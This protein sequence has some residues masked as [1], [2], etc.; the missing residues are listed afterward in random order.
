MNLHN[1]E[2]LNQKQQNQYSNNNNNDN[3]NNN[4]CYPSSTAIKSKNNNDIENNIKVFVRCRSRNQREIDEQ[5]NVVISTF[6]SSPGPSIGNNTINTNST[7]STELVLQQSRNLQKKFHFDKVFGAESDQ[8]KVY[9]DI[10]QS[11]IDEMLQGYNCTVFAYG[12][13]GTGKTYTMTGDITNYYLNSTTDEIVLSEHSGIIPR[14]LVDLF[15]NLNKKCDINNNNKEYSVKISFL[16]LYNEKLKDLLADEYSED[17]EVKIYDNIKSSNG[18]TT[19][20]STSNTQNTGSM[21]ARRS[22]SFYRNSNNYLSKRSFSS[23]NQGFTKN[24]DNNIACNNNFR[25]LSASSSSSSLS[26]SSENTLKTNNSNNNSNGNANNGNGNEKRESNRILSDRISH[27]FMRGTQSQPLYEVDTNV[28]NRKKT[29][30]NST[31]T[32]YQKGLVSST[33]SGSSIINP[34]NSRNSIL[35]KGVQEFFITS[36]LDGLKYLEEGSLKRQ[37]AATK[38]NDLSSRSHTI[39]TITTHVTTTDPLSGDEYVNVGKLN[40]VDLAGS[41]NINRSGAENKRAQEAGVINKSLLTLGRVINALVDHSAHIPYRES[42]L[43]RLLQDSLGGKTKTCIIATVS[44]AKVSMDETISTLEYATRAK[45]IKN[46][47]QINQSMVKQSCINEYVKII[48]NLRSELRAARKKEGVYIPTDTWEQ[49][50]N[51]QESNTTLI[52]EQKIKIDLLENQ[53]KRLKKN[54]LE[55]CNFVKDKENK[56]TEIT[57]IYQQTHFEKVRME[58]ELVEINENLQIFLD[59]SSIINEENLRKFKQLF[60]KYQSLINI[61]ESNQKVTTQT[62]EQILYSVEDLQ[63]VISHL[64]NYNTR[65]KRVLKSVSNELAL[66]YKS[67]IE[68]SGKGVMLNSINAFKGKFEEIYNGSFHK[69]TREFDAIIQAFQNE[70]MD[71]ISTTFQKWWDSD[72]AQL[73]KNRL[74]SNLELLVMDAKKELLNNLDVIQGQIFEKV[75]NYQ[76]QLLDEINIKALDS[77]SMFVS[78][79]DDLHHDAI[80]NLREVNFKNLKL[81]QENIEAMFT[82]MTKFISQTENQII[83]ELNVRNEETMGTAIKVFDD[84]HSKSMKTNE[85]KNHDV[86]NSIQSLKHHTSNPGNNSQLEVSLKEIWTD[87]KLKINKM[88]PSSEFFNENWTAVNNLIKNSKSQEL[89]NSRIAPIFNSNIVTFMNNFQEKLGILKQEFNNYIGLENSTTNKIKNG[90]LEFEKCLTNMDQYITN[91]YNNNISQVH[92]TQDEIL[93]EQTAQVMNVVGK[94]N[95]LKR[96]L[97]DME[98]CKVLEKKVDDLQK[99]FVFEPLPSWSVKLQQINDSIEKEEIPIAEKSKNLTPSQSTCESVEIFKLKNNVTPNGE[100]ISKNDQIF[101]PLSAT[102]IPIPDQP[103]PKMNFINNSNVKRRKVSNDKQ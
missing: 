17:K 81:Y 53:L 62:G 47:P 50:Q 70:F 71:T 13:T 64:N 74:V 92:I 83:H 2:E 12:Q 79:C 37:V 101:C 86:S 10:A 32:K 1:I 84:Y 5:S 94:L 73:L 72:I 14:I 90:I 97:N 8:E 27:N 68:G 98:D 87:D 45:S 78:T 57:G 39:F 9:Q 56:L 82:K 40:L 93:I 100:N 26:I 41:E 44:P 52:S 89:L 43:T 65:F 88:F 33:T 23:F 25:S 66:K 15:K 103:L 75:N 3:N 77:N 29:L 22:S 69:L 42:K 6:S 4:L 31:K 7:T 48:E 60:N 51:Q 28:N 91:E 80:S 55:Q 95:G 102:P 38:C 20:K 99:D 30:L 36:A 18:T 35:L 49:L 96:R 11:Y 59:K 21:L 58:N 16:E 54:F 67:L 76:C 24:S 61:Y 19:S 46:T 85:Q 63:K 34:T